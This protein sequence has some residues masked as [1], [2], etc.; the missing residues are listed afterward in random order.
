MFCS[1]NALP[2]CM[3][4]LCLL[5]SPFSWHLCSFATYCTHCEAAVA[6]AHTALLLPLQSLVRTCLVIAHVS[7][8]HASVQP[9]L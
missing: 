2:A 3:T 1:T 9:C 7:F 8:R 6:E 4:H 5:Q